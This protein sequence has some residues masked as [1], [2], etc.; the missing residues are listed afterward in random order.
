MS[1]R[2]LGA[3]IL[4]VSDMNKSV[5]FYRETLNLPLK[6]ESDEWTE[7]FNKETVLALH[8]ARH[9]ENL[10]S[11]QHI[12][13]GFSASDFDDTINKLKEKGVVFFKNPKEEGFG[14]HAII[15]DPDGHLISIVKLKSNQN[16]EDGFDFLGLVGAE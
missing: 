11:G 15:E 7:F 14:K 8:P 3:V 5:Q 2:K 1:F 13:L 6:K 12:L 9:K 4:L 10:K 16:E